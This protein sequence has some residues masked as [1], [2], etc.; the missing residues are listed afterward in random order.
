MPQVAWSTVAESDVEEIYEWIARRD[1]RRQTAKKVAR[2][3]RQRCEGLGQIVASG[4]LIGTA[5][6]DLGDGY[7]LFTHQRWVIVFRPADEGIEIMRV[8][9]GSRDYPRLFHE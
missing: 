2:E 1:G 4:S 3:L 7:R 6:P 5:R 8:L 9:D